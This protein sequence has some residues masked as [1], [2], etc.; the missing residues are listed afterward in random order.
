[1]IH[2]GMITQLPC[3]QKRLT[4]ILAGG[5]IAAYGYD[6]MLPL[7][8]AAHY[9]AAGLLVDVTCR[10]PDILSGSQEVVM[11]AAYGVGGAVAAS[12]MLGKGLK[13]M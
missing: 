12:L 10:G 8:R 7:P 3:Q 2:T 13:L 6:T 1:M 11:S 5:F 9:A 4:S